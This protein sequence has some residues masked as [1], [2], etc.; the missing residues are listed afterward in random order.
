GKAAVMDPAEALT[1]LGG[2]AASSPLLA[3]TSRR[4]LRRAVGAGL[5]HRAGR[6]R[7]VL[8]APDQARRAATMVNGVLILLSAAL[9]HGWE[10][11]LPPERPQIGV[12]RGRPV[13]ELRSAE[14]RR[15]DAAH[16]GWA[17]RHRSVTRDEFLAHARGP[18]QRRVAEHA[19][20]RAANPFESALRAILI[21][22][23]WA[24]VPQ[25]EVR[26][27]GLVL[28]P[29]LVDP[30]GGFVFEAES[31]EWHGKDREA[32]ERDCERYTALTVEGWRVLRFTWNE[33]V[34]RPDHVRACLRELAA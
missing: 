15:I 16:D 32:F 22:E 26:A 10:V 18:R 25:Y 2:I 6:D 27:R 4:A 34:H 20:G 9:H 13:V 7:Y 31:W 3:M 28:H 8:P 29:D 30:F 21:E 33:V 17:L 11:R 5:I 19:D 1:R 14:V 24:V 12:P 23:G